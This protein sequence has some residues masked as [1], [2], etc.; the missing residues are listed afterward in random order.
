V[1]AEARE[2]PL[3]S[4]V[5]A[6][7]CI[8]GAG[9][10]GITLAREFIGGSSRVVVLESGGT[11]FSQETQSLY[12]GENVGVPYFPL[13]APRLRYFG[14]TTNHWAGV[15]RPFDD[16]DFE[17]RDWIPYSGWPVSKT[18]L[19]PYYRRAQDVVRLP[20]DEWD[21]E[22]WLQADDHSPLRFDEGRIVTRVDQI[23][24][25]EQ[26]SFASL[27][28]EDLRTASNV[29][30]YLQANVRE[31]LMDE[32]GLGAESVRVVTL[33][34]N[35]FSVTARAFVVA[36]SGIENARLLLA[37]RARLPAGLGNQNDL[38][39]RF[40][41]EH[42]RFVA[43]VIAP[44]DPD[45]SVAF[46]EEHRVDDTIIQPRLA[47]A[48]AV[49]E[50]EGMAD[51]QFSLD[52]VYDPA[53][54][55][56]V[57]SADVESLRALRRV[58]ARR[59]MGDLGEHLSR[60]V[61]DLM[62]WH[63]V[64]VPGSPLPIPYPEV[65]GQLMR[66]TPRERQSLVPGL[67]G[68]V[69]AFL[70]TEFKGDLPLDTILVTAR[71]EP[72]PDPNS[73]VTLSDERDEIGMPRARLD[74]R[75]GDQDHRNVRRAMEILGEEVGAAGIGRL[76]ILNEDGGNDWPPD[77]AGGFHLIG[78]T[79]MHDDPKLGVVDAAGRVHGMSNLYVA[80]SS[81]FPTAGSGNPTML[82]VAL[83][84]RMADHLKEAL[85]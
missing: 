20:S 55:D 53:L 10:A 30:V 34:G 28:G 58:L 39:G 61:S 35:R 47:V 24:P 81:V 18:E 83:A 48:R 46:Y 6:D 84:L 33:D 63:R 42:P 72:I 26:R 78:T 51:V 59:G 73:R 65:I 68:D 29:T 32:T 69:A 44:A 56:A 66:S 82:I 60:V 8:V 80:G 54:E 52:P 85:G 74:W 70:Y 14:G 27:Y 7:L 4:A 19:D 79:R 13:D 45:A 12:E 1:F 36:V 22:A 11:E 76:R 40:F 23:V 5:A 2:V 31:I 77:L 64:T 49:Q 38:V 3:D 17:A 67:F 75:L 15:C 50:A 9:A 62:T 71:F 16:V 43:G 21:T 37:S 25:A 57:Q 41:L